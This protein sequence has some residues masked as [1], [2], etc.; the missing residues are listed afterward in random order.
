MRSRIGII[1]ASCEK[2]FKDLQ[3][4]RDLGKTHDCPQTKNHC[5]MP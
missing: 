1:D 3:G 4:K 2:S 5:G